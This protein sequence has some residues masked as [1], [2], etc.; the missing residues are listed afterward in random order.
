MLR[1]EAASIEDTACVAD[2]IYR[3]YSVL[4]ASA[5]EP[6]K[7]QAVLPAITK[8]NPALLSSGKYF[9]VFDAGTGVGCG[10]WSEATPGT[11]ETVP[12]LAHIRHFAVTPEAAGKGVGRLL[13]DRCR[14]EAVAAGFER[15]QAYSSLN[16]IDF[17]AK[18]G[19]RKIEPIEVPMTDEINFSGMIMEQ[20]I[21]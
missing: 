20:D 21:V 19:F 10:G 4:M 6:D 9:V 1:I 15:L 8:P 11:G 13:F 14:E 5:Y 7:L 12:G 18:M 2:V 16:A 17:Y 3:S